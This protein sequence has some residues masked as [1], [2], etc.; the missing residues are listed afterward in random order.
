MKCIFCEFISGSRKRHISGHPFEAINETK[1][2]VCFMSKDIPVAEDGHLLIIPKKHYI[3]LEVLPKHIL[4]ELI[5]HVSF[6]TKI[7]RKTNKGCNIFLND[8]KSAGQHI[9]HVHFHVIPR[10][11]GDNIKIDVWK[12]KKIAKSE[13]MKLNKKIKSLI[14]N[15]AN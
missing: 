14:K 6:V 1:N 2:T 5:D 3:Y 15:N 9:L 7:L 11:K 8:G 4:H 12:S 13:F 10:N